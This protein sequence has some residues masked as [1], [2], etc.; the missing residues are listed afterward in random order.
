MQALQN[1]FVFPIVIYARD[2]AMSKHV[3]YIGHVVVS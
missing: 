1:V 3:P 2:Q